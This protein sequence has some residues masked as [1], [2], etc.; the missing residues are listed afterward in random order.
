[1]NNILY[2]TALG[3][4]YIGRCEEKIV[5]LCEDS[6]LRRKVQLIMT[7]PPFPLNQKKE[8]GNLE[9]TEYIDWMS[10]L[11]PLFSELLT[12]DGSIVVEIG[13]GWE[14][15][16]PVQSLLTQKS[17]LAMVENPK[18]NLRLCQEF[19]CYNPARL[20]SPAQWVT[21][22]RIRTID[23]FTHV[24]WMAKTDFPKA[25]NRNILRP[26]S[27]SMER[28]LK[29][30]KYNAGRR[31]SDHNVSDEGFLKRHKGSIMPNV[32]EFETMKEGQDPRLPNNA[33]RIANTSSNDFFMKECRKRGLSPHPARMPMDLASFFISFLTN[34]GDLVLDPFGGSNT[35]GFCS[36]RLKRKW[37]SIDTDI[38]YGKQSAI[39]FED[40]TLETQ[41]RKGAIWDESQR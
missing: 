28:L 24:W 32:L 37:I 39:R 33:L 22:N 1:M 36:E 16:R 14:K 10:G 17:L 21:V 27:K 29:K 18:A 35:T 20:P 38:N 8:Y 11:S 2:S 26:Y 23:S 41:F 31:P 30:R 6:G 25:D 13:N 3:T 7:S 12:E 15:G 4:Y 9:G 5:S 40:P 19:I 34:E